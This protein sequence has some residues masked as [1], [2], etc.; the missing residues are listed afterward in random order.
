MNLAMFAALGMTDIHE[1]NALKLVLVT[2]INGVATA[3][4][5]VTGAI[6]W[7]Q[8][9]VMLAGAV[10]GGYTVAH[11]AQKLPHRLVRGLII[12]TGFGM[13]FYFLLKAYR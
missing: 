11:F 10:L 12:F 8:A 4:F 5:V 6:V 7:P 13:T 9:L 3:T 2:V 1:M